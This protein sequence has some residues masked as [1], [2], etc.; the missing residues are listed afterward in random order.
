MKEEQ[1]CLISKE[2]LAKSRWVP[3]RSV[4]SQTLHIHVR[5]F[6]FQTICQYSSLLSLWQQLLYFPL[7]FIVQYTIVHSRVFEP[8]QGLWESTS[9]SKR[10]PTSS[11]FWARHSVPMSG[12]S[13]AAAR[14]SVTKSDLLCFS[15]A[16]G[17]SEDHRPSRSSGPSLF[18]VS[19]WHDVPS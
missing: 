12:C 5:S 18:A 4:Q 3:F 16:R 7:N 6:L 9:T 2:R 17:P 8:A 14:Q 10:C 13:P 1:K 19:N 15:P 11:H